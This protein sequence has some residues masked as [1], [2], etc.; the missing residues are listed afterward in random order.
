M[1]VCLHLEVV[2]EDLVRSTK[3]QLLVPSV[4]SVVVL[5]LEPVP[6]NTE[7]LEVCQELAAVSVVVSAVE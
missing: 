7:V 6:T 1:E 3:I 2:V 4:R 5:P